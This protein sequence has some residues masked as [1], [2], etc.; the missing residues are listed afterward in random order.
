MIGLVI[1][2]MFLLA[3]GILVTMYGAENH[4]RNPGLAW[5][6]QAVTHQSYQDI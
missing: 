4:R 2:F 3:Y 6:D 5:P 1:L